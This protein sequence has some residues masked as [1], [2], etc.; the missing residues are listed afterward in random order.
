VVRQIKYSL[1]GLCCWKLFW[2]FFSPFVNRILRCRPSRGANVYLLHCFWLRFS[3]LLSTCGWHLSPI[4]F[5][6]RQCPPLQWNTPPQK[7]GNIRIWVCFRSKTCHCMQ[8][9]VRFMS[10]R[11]FVWNHF[12]HGCST[13]V[14]AFGYTSL[15]RP[16]LNMRQL[17]GIHILQETHTNSTNSRHEWRSV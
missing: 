4:Y 5:L 15:V 13:E 1:F 10:L 12:F 7:V 2:K 3:W 11:A 8:L 16:Q 9:I 6:T 17:P 14:K